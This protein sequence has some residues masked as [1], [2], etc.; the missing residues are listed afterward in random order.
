M[1]ENCK[2]IIAWLGTGFVLKTTLGYM[3]LY[4]GDPTLGECDQ[5][6]NQLKWNHNIQFNQSTIYL[7]TFLRI[8]VL[9]L[10]NLQPSSY[11]QSKI[12]SLLLSHIG[13]FAT[14]ILPGKKKLMDICK[15]SHDE[16]YF[17]FRHLLYKKEEPLAGGPFPPIYLQST[18]IRGV[19]DSLKS[20]NSLKKTVNLP[21]ICI[22][23]LY[24]WKAIERGVIVTHCVWWLVV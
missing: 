17:L 19:Q 7:I 9:A 6:T 10:Q 22:D 3:N 15:S 14:K 13:C 1:I 20:V 4:W 5:W 24:K 16:L 23:Q 8:S 18:W 11:A 2:K 12:V 21:I